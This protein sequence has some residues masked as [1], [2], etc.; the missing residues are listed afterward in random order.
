[1]R[2][3][4]GLG[5]AI[6]VQ[7][8]GTIEPSRMFPTPSIKEHALPKPQNSAA[9]FWRQ[10]SLELAPTVQLAHDLGDVHGVGSLSGPGLLLQLPQDHRTRAGA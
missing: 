5:G 1:M 6:G 3:L 7:H 4:A 2:H 9:L 10:F 8:T